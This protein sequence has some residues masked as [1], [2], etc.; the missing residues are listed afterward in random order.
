MLA[1]VLSMSRHDYFDDVDTPDVV[2]GTDLLP[3]H[4]TNLHCIDMHCRCQAG[5]STTMPNDLRGMYLLTTA[6]HNT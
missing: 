1:L 3:P 2:S 4:V 6:L 5:R